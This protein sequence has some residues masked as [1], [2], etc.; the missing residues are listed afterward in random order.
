MSNYYDV[1]ILGG[2]ING[3]L[4]AIGLSHK[5]ISVLVVEERDAI[6]DGNQG[7]VYAFSKR[8]KEILENFSVWNDE[9]RS[10]P[11]DHIM[12]Y[13]GN[14]CSSVHYDRV[15][16]DDQPM[17][18]VVEASEIAKFMHQKLNFDVITSSSCKL[19]TV[20][21]GFA[22]IYLSCGKKI[23]T[24]LVVCAEGKNSRFR[25]SLSLKTINYAFEQGFIVCNINHSKHHRNTAIEH[26][27][28]NGP[29]AILPMYGGYSSSIVWT[30]KY[31]MAQL[32]QNLPIEEFTKLL[33][34]KCSD[35]LGKIEVNSKINC[36]KTSMSLLKKIFI[37]R[38]II[39]GDAA[40][41]IH[42][43]AG[44]GLNLGIRDVGILVEI[45]E[46]YHKLGS[47]IGQRFIL[48]E[49]DNRRLLDNVS[50]SFVCTGINSI[51]SNDSAILKVA[52]RATMS[53]VEMSPTL[54]KI[55]MSHAMG[56]SSICK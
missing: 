11:I 9:I 36:Y 55:L 30:E 47:D 38:A 5:D 25:N 51:F 1:V 28:T 43:V 39:I 27:C 8:S 22:E 45:I 6:L 42:P 41:A 3:V 14:S 7:R 15:L 44:Q 37:N 32:I 16:V 4:C 48:Q 31:E 35:F 24:K 10:S 50:M 46:K 34:E 19:F 17:G 49:I 54:K 26:F 23:Y 13:D 12:I 52:R 21:D 56:I 40:H 2:G 53:V 29:F 33:Q 18:Y 20:K